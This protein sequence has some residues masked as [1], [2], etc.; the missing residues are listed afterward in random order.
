MFPP[1]SIKI[2]TNVF[3]KLPYDIVWKW[4][5]DELPGRPKNVEISKWLPQSDL[6]SKHLEL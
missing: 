2:F 6:L 3:S 5:N 1:E 4:D